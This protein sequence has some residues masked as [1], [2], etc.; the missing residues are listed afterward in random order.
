MAH[1]HP[2]ALGVSQ[3]DLMI[4][5]LLERAQRATTKATQ[6]AKGLTAGARQRDAGKKAQAAAD[7]SRG[8][9]TLQQP[10][11]QPPGAMSDRDM[12]R[13]VKSAKSDISKGAAAMG[14]WS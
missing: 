5:A 7:P 10:A 13:A 4:V 14:V 6:P 2:T 1:N 8:M 12:R 11:N 9:R 3:R